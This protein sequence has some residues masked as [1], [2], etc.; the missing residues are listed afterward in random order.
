[1]GQGELES[2][3][4]ELL[5]VGSA[6]VLGLVDLGDADDVDRPEAGAVAGREV[7]VHLLD[8]LGAREGA[9]LLDHLG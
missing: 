9:V 8:R 3:L 4:E 7:L 6:N 5:D 1:M 2:G